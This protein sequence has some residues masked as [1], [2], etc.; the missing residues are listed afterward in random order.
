MTVYNNNCSTLG[1]NLVHSTSVLIDVKHRHISRFT[2][3]FFLFPKNEACIP[4]IYMVL[5]I[6]VSS[7]VPNKLSQLDFKL[8][9]LPHISAEAIQTAIDAK[10]FL[11]FIKWT[12]S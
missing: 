5:I 8:W 6:C 1:L 10:L 12:E 4:Q 9:F 3:I 2:V 7:T 11:C